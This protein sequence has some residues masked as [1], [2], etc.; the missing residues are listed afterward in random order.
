MENAKNSL[1]DPSI[2]DSSDDEAVSSMEPEISTRASGCTNTSSNDEVLKPSY[3]VPESF[4]VLK[5]KGASKGNWIFTCQRCYFKD[6]S[7]SYKS[8][9]N[10]RLHVKSKH[11]GALETF[12][13]LC[14]E[15]D[16]RKRKKGPENTSAVASTSKYQDVM[17][18]GT[19][20]QKQFDL[21]NL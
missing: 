5:G 1:E 19:L 11:N 7:A 3:F 14:K 9:V 6:F 17:K 8:R 16:S 10:L 13:R 18:P 12:D 20:T 4:F 21:Y 2:N 15:N